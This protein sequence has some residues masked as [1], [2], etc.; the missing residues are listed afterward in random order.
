MQSHQARAYVS[1]GYSAICMECACNIHA[2]C[3]QRA[4]MHA[5]RGTARQFVEFLWLSLCLCNG[6]SVLPGLCACANEC[7]PNAACVP[8]EFLG[9]I[10]L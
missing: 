1:S 3:V 4:S 8:A 10:C 5:F 7:L 2:I 9:L 6:V